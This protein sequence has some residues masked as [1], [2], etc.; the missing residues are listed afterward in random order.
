MDI[1]NKIVGYGQALLSEI[2]PNPK[3]W[4]EHPIYQEK[5]VEGALEEVGI[6]Q[7]VII[8]K[9]T[10]HLID[11]H[12][13]V[14]IAKKRGLIEIPATYVE[15]TQD[16]ENL[17]LATYDTSTEMAEKNQDKLNDLIEEIHSENADVQ[18]A[19]DKLHKENESKTEEVLVKR[20][21]Q[22]QPAQEYVMIVC[23][24]QTEFEDIRAILG[25]GMVRRGGYKKGSAFDDVGAERLM[26]AGRFKEFLN[27]YRNPK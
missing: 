2:I 18:T 3:N 14:E 21:I 6:I 13:R 23:K 25:L 8:N 20:S 4:R 10:G 19:L 7:T 24:D 22:L 15:M 16:E 26:E 11:G 5:F 9:T 27:A 1:Q 17:A 12:L